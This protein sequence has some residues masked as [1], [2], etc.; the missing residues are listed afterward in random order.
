VLYVQQAA[1]AGTL[2]I[3]HNVYVF[4]RYSQNKENRGFSP[5]A[6]YTGQAAAACRRS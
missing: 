4:L 3:S 6:N 1:A 5:Q 2:H